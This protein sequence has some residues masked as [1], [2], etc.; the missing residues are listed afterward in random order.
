[1]GKMAEVKQAKEAKQAE[2]AAKLQAEKEARVERLK[3]QQA[4]MA[5][6]R[7]AK[8]LELAEKRKLQAEESASNLADLGELAVFDQDGLKAQYGDE[9]EQFPILKLNEFVRKEYAGQKIEFKDCGGAP[10]TGYK[11]AA[12]LGSV[13]VLGSA[14][15]K[16]EGKQ[17]AAQA[18]LMALRA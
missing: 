13:K 11:F 18:L 2:L 7:E 9:L 1:M 8:K 10:D 14:K 4:E 6:K 15:S 5:A 3:A 12:C 17:V 16:K